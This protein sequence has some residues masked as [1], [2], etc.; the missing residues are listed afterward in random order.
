MGAK[1]NTAANSKPRA[2]PKPNTDTSARLKPG[3]KPNVGVSR[4]K[5][6]QS[7]LIK[8]FKEH[9]DSY[10]SKLRQVGGVWPDGSVAESITYF[11]RGNDVVTQTIDP[12]TGLPSRTYEI[13]PGLAA[14]I[15]RGGRWH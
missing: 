11:T 15:R 13:N 12:V 6:D 9:R 8:R 3:S 10:F 2:I 4:K 7:A 14:E 1:T 5:D